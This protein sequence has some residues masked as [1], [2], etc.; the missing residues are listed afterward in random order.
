M[1]ADT[2]DIANRLGRDLSEEETRSYESILEAVSDEIN[3]QVGP[4]EEISDEAV[5]R[6]FKGTAV[7][8]AIRAKANP[9]G[10]ASH[11]KTLGAVSRSETFPRSGDDAGMINKTEI[12]TLRRAMWGTNVGSPKMGSVLDDIHG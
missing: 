6:V 7:T 9:N 8:A 10:V 11:S 12:R 5:L 2:S 3:V 1:Y 4:A